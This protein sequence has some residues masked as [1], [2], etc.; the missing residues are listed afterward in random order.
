MDLDEAVA[1]VVAQIRQFRP[2]VVVTHDV[3]GQLTGH[4][5]HRRTHQVALLAVEA[6]AVAQLCPEA[7]NRGRRRLFTQLHIPTP[8]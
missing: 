2:E 5:D 1:Q 3:L 4:P 7:A 6:A 8:H